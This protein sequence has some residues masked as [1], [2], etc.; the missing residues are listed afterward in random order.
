MS[1]VYPHELFVLHLQVRKE[2]KAIKAT[3]AKMLAAERIAIRTKIVGISSHR[4]LNAACAF[5]H[6]AMY[7]RGYNPS[8]AA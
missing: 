4:A 6:G 2:C 8:D 7:G 5:L 1:N 3:R